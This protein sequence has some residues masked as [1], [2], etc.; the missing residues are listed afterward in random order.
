MK[1]WLLFGYDKYYPGG[2]WTDLLQSYDMYNA[3]VDAM[4][5]NVYGRFD[6]HQIVDVTT[7]NAQQFG[8]GI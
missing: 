8:G 4:I 5:L 2:G 7:G 3:A 6:Y 1:R